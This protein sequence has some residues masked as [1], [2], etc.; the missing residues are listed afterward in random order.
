MS[1]NSFLPPDELRRVFNKIGQRFTPQREEIWRLFEKSASGLT[2][3][4]ATE[5][6]A[7][8][9]IGQATV[10]RTVK[11]LQEMGYLKWVHDLG[12]EHRFVASR[13]EHCHLLVCRSCAKA[14]ECPDC[15]IATMEKLIA[16]QTGFLVE[17]HHLEF[18]GLCPDCSK[19]K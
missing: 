6:L 7:P 19:E 18:F 14:V 17:G 4:Q 1:E 5:R 10:Y 11:A 3:S 12:G 8:L 2:I 15:D 9:G 13:P 16:M